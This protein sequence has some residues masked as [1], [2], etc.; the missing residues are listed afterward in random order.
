LKKERV[1]SPIR[2]HHSKNQ[3]H[4]SRKLNIFN[5]ATSS[6]GI[7]SFVVNIGV[8]MIVVKVLTWWI[9]G[10]IRLITIGNSSTGF[11]GHT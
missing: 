5:N 8:D 6:G 10:F 2:P 4:Q 1:L 3:G 7:V 11:W 9:A